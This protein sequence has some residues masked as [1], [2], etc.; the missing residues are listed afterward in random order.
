MEQGSAADTTAPG[1]PF[2]AGEMAQRVRSHDWA[3]TPL[4]PVAQWPA[5]LRTTVQL[6]LA[7]PF[8]TIV[9]W[10]PALVQVY[11]DAY[12]DL[13]GAKHPGGL[14]QPTRECWPE[15][16]HIN[17]PIYERVWRGESVQF[18]D[19]LYPL[20][21]FGAIEDVWLS[22]SYSPVRDEGGRVAG[23]FITIIETTRRLRA[24]AALR[25]REARQAFLLRLS[26][27]LR[28]L[29][30]AQAIKLEA[31]RRLG[32]HLGAG[33]VLYA[34][35]HGDDWLVTKGYEHGVA[36]LPEGRYAASTYG[37]WIMRDYRAGCRVVIDDACGDARFSAAECDAH[38]AVQVLAMIGVPLVKEGRLVAVLVVH[39]AAPR[40][41]SGSETALVEE[42][43][44]RTWAAVERAGAEAALRASEQR[45]RLALDVGELASWD[46]DLD[47]DRVVWSE[48]HYRMQG[49]VPGEV[50]PSYAAWVARVHPDDRAATTAA[51]DAARHRHAPYQHEFRTVHPDGAVRWLSARGFFFHDDAGRARRMVGVMRDVT[52]PRQ[53]RALLEQRVAERTHALRQLLQHLEGLQD[54]ERRRIARELHDGLGQVLSSVALAVS[55]LRQ[56]G[57]AGAGHDGQGQDAP[58]WRQRVEQLHGLM[59][60]LD[61]E[62]D[63]IVFTLRPTALEDCGLGEG[64][65]AYAQ[66]WSQLTGVAVDLELHGL[67]QGRLSATVEAAVFRVVQEALN[68]VAKYAQA[69]QVSV[70]LQRRRGLLAGSVEDDGVGF[71]AAEATA[72]AAGRS[73]WGLLGMQERI[74]ALGGSFAIDSQPGTGTTVL[75]RL[76]LA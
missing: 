42:T 60:H 48:E 72:G 51:L 27:A 74:E 36:P 57:A 70:S 39:A 31:T 19:A 17:A 47:T 66:T 23:V 16:W 58:A 12:R 10:G 32:E 2:A 11:N 41:W 44:E 6:V 22:L 37:A 43:A 53:A 5:L 69:S 21:R 25:E 7:H 33:R 20:A 73:R 50:E 40:A 4:G 59:Q 61:R 29:Q 38:V 9:L 14:G 26:D 24:E 56:A 68:N 34:E 63:R 46:W 30:D 49:Y 3:A 55:T 28:P 71:D 67:E 8:A 45:L 35:V 65:A 15:V 75:W 13:M 62:L 18:E 64:V 76:P 52:E 54:E 1:W